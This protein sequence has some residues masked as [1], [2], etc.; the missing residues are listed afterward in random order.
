MRVLGH[1]R[2]GG[3]RIA[4]A[5]LVSLP[6][7][8]QFQDPPPPPEDSTPEEFEEVDPHTRGDPAALERL[9]YEGFGPFTLPGGAS[10]LEL[11][12][13]LG[14]VSM[15]WV[16]TAHFKLGSTLKT[17]RLQGDPREAD[18]LDDELERLRRKLTRW[19]KPRN[20]LDP[21]LRLHL[22]AQ[23]L[24]DLHATF[25]GDFDL[26]PDAFQLGEPAPKEVR[27]AGAPAA[28][29]FVVILFEKTSGLARYTSHVLGYEQ[30]FSLRFTFP[31]GGQ[32]YGLAAESFRE[33]GLR[34]DAA[35]HSHL[36]YGQTHNHLDRL[37]AV[38]NGVPLWFR[39]GLGQRYARSPDPRWTIFEGPDA[40]RTLREGAWNWEPRVRGLVANEVYPSWEEMMAWSTPED[41]DRR[42]H[43]ITWSR[44]DWLL[45][46]EDGR[47]REFLRA[48][49]AP[50]SRVSAEL[51][52]DLSTKRQREGLHAAWEASPAALEKGWAKHVRRKYARR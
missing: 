24:E 8:G 37:S 3:G 52:A 36:V 17:Y 44:V 9:G 16:E 45:G 18:K 29:K 26:D 30:R 27:S 51:Q 5:A 33:K 28:D 38:W 15:L 47:P 41:L 13:I 10:T 21:W 31:G 34:L 32:F 12:R 7:A 40:E 48:V 23:R 49:C 6:A 25:C 2:R 20:E 50:H 46:L 43:M 19:K 11:E 1:L 4:L 22:Y 35:L 14:G 42:A 39:Y